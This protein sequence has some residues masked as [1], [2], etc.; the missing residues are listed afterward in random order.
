MKWLLVV[1]AI[2]PEEVIGKR[3]NSFCP[4]EE[5]CGTDLWF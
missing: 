1:P 3:N 4:Y 2:V 5:G